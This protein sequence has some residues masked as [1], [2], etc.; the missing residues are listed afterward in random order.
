MVKN[1]INNGRLDTV[2]TQHYMLADSIFHD[3]LQKMQRI[4]LG[5]TEIPSTNLY[6]SS[7]AK[8]KS[9]DKEQKKLVAHLKLSAGT[10]PAGGGKH[11]AANGKHGNCPR[12]G[13]D[14]RHYK[15]QKQTGYGNGTS[16]WLNV[17]GANYDLCSEVNSKELRLCKSGARDGVA[18][19]F[20]DKYNFLHTT[21][22]NDLPV[23]KRKPFVLHIDNTPG[24]E[25]L[26]E[27]DVLAKIQSS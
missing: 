25:I 2:P 26:A 23:E 12:P 24:V 22:I 5:S 20:K 13:T 6:L 9:D 11:T 4:F 16:G 8:K 17:T 14:D 10:Q 7:A 18:C 3:T 21:S 19:P 15:K 1:A 27:A